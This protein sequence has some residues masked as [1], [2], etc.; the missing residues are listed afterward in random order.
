M[1][2]NGG[3]NQEDRIFKSQEHRTFVILRAEDGRSEVD[4]EIPSHQPVREWLSDLIKI[5]WPHV[6]SEHSI[7]FRLMTTSG[8][9]LLDHETIHDAGIK[10][11]DVLWI[12]LTST[13]TDAEE[14]KFINHQEQPRESEPTPESKFVIYDNDQ[15]KDVFS[16]T[17]SSLVSASGDV[18]VLG[19]PPIAIGRRSNKYQP[20]ID[21]TEYDGKSA[22]SR[23]HAMILRKGSRWV[24]LARETTNGTFL[25]GVLV[26]P[27][28]LYTLKHGDIIQF[29][30]DG[31]E[32]TFCSGT[33]ES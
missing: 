8:R 3:M 30:Q 33:V 17:G 24:L 18:F 14:A 23:R 1:V 26:P 2:E 20:D 22:V 28:D 4:M 15:N 32:L 21:L 9:I 7:E 5:L 31:V 13:D 29:G 11:Y 6:D 12:S 16:N 27:D 10:N 19:T 25:N